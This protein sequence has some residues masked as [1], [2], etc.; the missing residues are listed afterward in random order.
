LEEGALTRN[1][2]MES[3][4]DALQPFQDPKSAPCHAPFSL[5]ETHVCHEVEE[6]DR[7]TSPPAV[8]PSIVTSSFENGVDHMQVEKRKA[9]PREDPRAE[10]RARTQEPDTQDSGEMK[11]STATT[12]ATPEHDR[13]PTQVNGRRSQFIVN[14]FNQCADLAL[15]RTIR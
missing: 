2:A 14:I 9:S 5:L 3:R 12:S 6:S 4:S 7:P 10:K 11:P 15:D 13:V 8:T 1:T